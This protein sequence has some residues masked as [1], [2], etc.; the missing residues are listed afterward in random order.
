VEL[1][2]GVDRPEKIR[3]VTD[4]PDSESYAAEI[5]EVLLRSDP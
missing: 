5:R 2:L 1:G 3:L 4:D